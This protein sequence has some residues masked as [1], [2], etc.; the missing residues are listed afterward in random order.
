MSP[1]SP[2]NKNIR[3]IEIADLKELK[4]ASEGWYIEYKREP[5]NAGAIAKSISAFSNTYG[6]WLFIGVEEESKENPVAG[7]F[8]GVPRRDV[9]S[10]LQR[11]RKSATDH[12][13]PTP[14]FETK[15]LW[16]PDSDTGL[17]DDHAVICVWVPQSI[18]APHI[19]KTGQIYRR[20]SDASEPKPENDR[21]VLDQLWRRAD[22]IKQY[23][24]E[25]YE[26]D[27]EFS[28]GEEDRPYVRLMLVAD[29]WAERDVWIDSDNDEVRAALNQE[30]GISAIPFDNFYTLGD[31]LIGRQLNG[32][33]PQNLT[34][35]WRLRRNLI[36]D[37]IIPLPLSEPDNV[38]I[39]K[40]DF[41]GYANVQ[42]LVCLLK[43]YQSGATRVVD[44]NY[45]FNILIGVAEIQE[46]LCKLADWRENYF[47]KVKLLNSWR[48]IPF[49]DIPEVLD[50]F[51]K[52]GP[53][54]C[55]DSIISV[56]RQTGPDK[57]IEVL[58]HDDVENHEAKML[59]QALRM[60][61]PL[62]LSYGIPDWLPYDENENRTPYFRSLQ[63]AGRSALEVQKNRNDRHNK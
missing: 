7:K 40:L 51:D 21:F 20:V 31:E 46:R 53:P 19:H 10:S 39:L 33:D 22:E 16:G 48:T 57:Y 9:D 59:L 14:H 4:Q 37:V 62:A 52:H 5:P 18:S 2:F 54:M 32:N 11:L 6:G 56:P 41:Y 12:L 58:R 28:K 50:R 26:R 34:L 61:M 47:I 42:R 17:V 3:D 29:P 23:H 45:L 13:N 15:V 43:K 35:T 55:L 1:Y 49:V 63:E 36:S 27:P 38:D 24:R 30:A 8:P 44:I 25:W 60:F